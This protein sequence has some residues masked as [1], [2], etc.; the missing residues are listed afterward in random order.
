MNERPS[1][2][3]TRI[4]KEP[5]PTEAE[6]AH[7]GEWA[8]GG[9]LSMADTKTPAPLPPEVPAPGTVDFIVPAPPASSEAVTKIHG[10]NP[11]VAEAPAP[12]GEDTTPTGLS[13]G[14][15]EILGTL[16]RGAMG[17]VYK[18]RQ[19]G[20]KRVVALKMIS[21]GMH[22]S[23]QHRSRFRAEAEAAATLQHPNLV[24][25]YEIGEH[26]GQ[27]YISLE[28]VDGD[29]LDRKIGGTPQ[30][31]SYAA[32]V[33]RT[34]ALAMA[35]AH[36]TRIIHR[37][38]KPA[39]ILLTAD[40]TPKIADFGLAKSLEDDSAHTQTG[41]IMGTPSYMA[42]EQAEGKTRQVGT[43][44]DIYAL[45][46]ILYDLLTGR[47][48]FRAATALDTLMQ[49]ATLEPVPPRQLQPSIPADLETICLKCLQK[50][51]AKRYASA[52]DLAEDLRR[53]LAGEA[54]RARPVSVPERLW[55]WC[56]RNPVL[57]SLG[58][59]VVL[60]L[61]VWAASSTYL[62]FQIRAEM[63]ETDRQRQLADALAK[64]A[65]DN[66]QIAKKNETR[67]QQQ[68][69]KAEKN[70]QSLV[71]LFQTNVVLVSNLVEKLSTRLQPK[72]GQKLT[73]EAAALRK[74]FLDL[75]RTTMSKMAEDF[76][77]TGISQFGMA[78][79]H[80][81]MGDLLRKLGLAEEA[82]QQYQLG[83]EGVRQLLQAEPGND[84]TRGNLALLLDR[85]G[86]T[87]LESRGTPSA[88]AACF[89]E[90]LE[91]NAVVLDHLPR[92]PVS[93]KDK[94]RVAEILR[95]QINTH[96]RLAEVAGL[97][98]DPGSARKWLQTPLTFW[99][100]RSSDDPTGDARSYLSQTH[101]LLGDACSW[102]GDWQACQEHHQAAVHLCG[103]LV[104]GFPKH[105]SFVA[106]LALVSVAHGDAYLR[107][108]Q[109]A[110]ARKLY[111]KHLANVE[112][113]ARQNPGN[114]WVQFVLAHTYQRL[115]ALSLQE[116]QS[117]RAAEMLNK[118][119][120]K[121]EKLAREQ[122]QN[123]AYQAALP[124][125]LARCGK[126]GPAREK[127]EALLKQTPKHPEVL[128]QSARCFAVCAAANPSEKLPLGEKAV[129]LLRQAV[130][131][132]YRNTAALESDPDWQGIRSE[133]AFGQVLE[134]AKR[135]PTDK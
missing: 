23:E 94:K 100:F 17:V 41:T 61:V 96:I 114:R 78:V 45:G 120:T 97:M 40:G 43:A 12:L 113:I 80:Q 91:L 30:P 57:A 112:A 88:A 62:Y 98:W 60:L 117:A 129:Q 69:A 53:F 21:S 81:R 84:T 126:E 35:Y 47:P 131:Q 55:R 52:A 95:N 108:G 111:E 79:A 118:S 105:S 31:P 50:E 87:S 135:P 115:G 63:E 107:Q 65:R 25:I 110:E 93:D 119:L 10:S 27:P 14:G 90:A 2:A 102:S 128:I 22:A 16:G 123:L 109:K 38:L 44:A 42:P 18:A 8:Q 121:W 4:E 74:E 130:E 58:A 20:L 75:A 64:T 104:K 24:Q 26:E 73:P 37:D 122:P 28:F 86:Q 106:D 67:A 7:S 77:K 103:A 15:Y 133:A 70:A 68:Q 49:V 116:G 132:G 59:A 39:N 66:E 19:R 1:Q 34:L 124:V 48:P 85:L 134:Q 72:G 71:G 54:I 99:K 11:S 101:S 9:P 82:R 3:D 76:S 92:K 29:R 46:A 33:V 83:V 56:R 5:D 127:A 51:P 13:V 36:H 125:A 89:R 6:V 32:E